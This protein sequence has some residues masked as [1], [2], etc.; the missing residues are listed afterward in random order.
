MDKFSYNQHSVFIVFS[1]TEP[2][3]ELQDKSIHTARLAEISAAH[4][5]VIRADSAC[6]CRSKSAVRC[7]CVLFDD[8]SRSSSEFAVACVCSAPAVRIPASSAALDNPSSTSSCILS[9]LR[10]T[11]KH[12]ARDAGSEGC[13]GWSLSERVMFTL[14]WPLYRRAAITVLMRSD[15]LA[16]ASGCRP[17]LGRISISNFCACNTAKSAFKL[18]TAESNCS[19]HAAFFFC[20]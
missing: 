2:R 9:K 10:P 11:P 17:T 8:N 19:L 3:E 16:R 6:L 18:C 5:S 13:I 12:F 4:N 20:F 15:T 14:H 7:C 1:S